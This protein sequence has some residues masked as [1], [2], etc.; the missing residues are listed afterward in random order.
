MRLSAL[1]RLVRQSGGAGAAEFAFVA[2][3]F[4]AMV[5]AVI[6]L[7]IVIYAVACLHAA[8]EAASRCASI[9]IPITG[10]TTCATTDEIQ[11]YAASK[12]AGPH[13]G[14]S[15]AYS[16]QPCGKQVKATGSYKIS[17]IVANISVPLTAQACYP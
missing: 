17:I 16:V 10:S 6:H 5:F 11:T 8:S 13:V 12:Y 15:F 7:G 3:A 9:N 2:P 1:G 4:L 14:Q